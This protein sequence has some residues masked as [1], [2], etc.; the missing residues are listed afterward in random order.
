MNSRFL[1]S[2]VISGIAALSLAACSVTPVPELPSGDVPAAWEKAKASESAGWPASD[3]WRS[4][5]SG[6][7]DQLI[8]QIEQQNLDLE[9]NRTNLE[10]AQLTLR[11][12]GFNRFPVPTVTVGADGRYTGDKPD[13]GNYSD[14][15]NSGADLTLGVV[16]SDILSKPA[17]YD[18]AQAGYDA[19]VALA[20]DTRLNTLA[21]AA[22]TYFG[23]LLLRDRIR[24]AE[25]NVENAETI[26]RI[27]QSRAKAGVITNLD[28]LQQ[29]IAVDTLKANLRSLKQDEY[30]ARS[31][32]ALMLAAS[33]QGFDV[34]GTTLEDVA[35]P[36]VEPGL[37][38][39][40][41]ERRPDIV[42]ARSELVQSAR[43]VDLAK[44]QYLPNISLTG[45][46]S[47]VSGSLK[48]LLSASDL[49]VDGAVS[50]VELLFD[51]GS[52]G[53]NVE[54]QRLGLEASLAGYRK[55]VIGAFND[56][57]VNLSNIELLADLSQVAEENLRHAEE[58]FHLAEVRY[59]AG[60]VDYE[61]VLV[62][63]TT[64]FNARNNFL[65]SKLARLN[66]VIKLYLAL[67]GGWQEG[68]TQAVLASN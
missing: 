63:Q 42:R 68:E 15:T 9:I 35:I 12:A 45:S 5:Q 1:H 44:L 17:E 11:D 48:N 19:S 23:V 21:T 38:S 58:A 30:A 20:A 46:A 54:R 29:R 31:A 28:V 24:A 43:D 59:R 52:R 37:T 65:D 16:Y 40:L 10:Q 66:A 56:I 50:A 13:G 25:S 33:V 4:F 3:W 26:Y 18:V 47:L 57:E 8:G 61:T 60:A 53:R 62:A 64:L 27:T 2:L 14:S 49:F 67:G 51:N 41:L 7:L 22:S 55:T 36:V 39:N 6:E 32:L 34:E